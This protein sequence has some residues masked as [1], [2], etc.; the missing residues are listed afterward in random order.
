MNG[1]HTLPQP[2]DSNHQF[3]SSNVPL[4]S[5]TLKHNSIAS[6]QQFQQTS[7]TLPRRPHS[8]AQP[9]NNIRNQN[10]G[11]ST[12]NRSVTGRLLFFS[13]FFPIVLMFHCLLKPL[14]EQMSELFQS[15]KNRLPL[16]T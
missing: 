5:S 6:P 12:P 10:S 7:Q 1:H 15:N 16:Q 4:N 11:T 8:V 14:T 13:R 3:S 9:N 2:Y